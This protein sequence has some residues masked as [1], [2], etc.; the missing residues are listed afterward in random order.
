MCSINTSARPTC[1]KSLYSLSENT[2]SPIRSRSSLP[3]HPAPLT[4]CCWCQWLTSIWLCSRGLKWGFTFRKEPH[5]VVS[6]IKALDECALGAWLESVICS[7]AA[8]LTLEGLQVP[9]FAVQYLARY[10]YTFLCLLLIKYVTFFG[11][12]LC[13]LWIR[14]S[15]SLSAFQ[16]QQE[17]CKWWHDTFYI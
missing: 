10:T 5:N 17:T 13:C 8:F 9:L 14:T 6:R 4:C 15:V 11:S 12:Q 16:W 1:A 7:C 3:P 2:I